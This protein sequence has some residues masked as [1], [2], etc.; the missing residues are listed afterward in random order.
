MTAYDGAYPDFDGTQ[1]C[2]DTDVE[3]FF[4]ASDRGVQFQLA[5]AVCTGCPFQHACAEYAITTYSD[6]V[7]G[8]TSPEHRS[9]IRRKRARLVLA[10]EAVS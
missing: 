8:G 9:R 3:L 4:P 5:K 2:A 7:W 1:N 6:G 10:N